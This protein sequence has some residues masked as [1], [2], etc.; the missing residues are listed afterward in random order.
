MLHGRFQLF[1][2]RGPD[3]QVGAQPGAPL[4]GRLRGGAGGR[5]GIRKCL[6]LGEAIGDRRD[7]LGCPLRGIEPPQRCRALE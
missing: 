1:D 6:G 2:A 5:D 7:G 3:V 4:D